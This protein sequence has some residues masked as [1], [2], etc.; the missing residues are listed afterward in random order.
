MK[1]VFG[2]KDYLDN[3]LVKE[4]NNVIHYDELKDNIFENAEI[5]YIFDSNKDFE[6]KLLKIKNKIKCPIVIIGKSYILFE[7]ARENNLSVLVY[8]L[9]EIFGKWYN[10]DRIISK[11][12]S[13][14]ETC[15]REDKNISCVMAEDLINELASIKPNEI[16]SEIRSFK[17]VYNVNLS[18]IY[19]LIISFE[20]VRENRIIPNLSHDF[21][22]KLWTVYLSYLENEDLS[23]ELITHKDNRGSFTE[24]LK[25]SS[26][27]QMSIN[28][29]KPGIMKG[30]HWHKYNNKKYLVLKGKGLFRLRKIY[31]DK[32]TEYVTTE[33]KFEIIDIPAGYVYTIENIGSEDMVIVM[34]SSELFDPNNP[35]SYDLEI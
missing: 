19:D 34:W 14:I 11:M 35:D 9:P 15:Q 30:N 13:S 16:N 5:I 25:N 7:Q 22:K 6:E 33:E 1:L 8:N 27:G 28:V 31:E 3:L 32:I 26:F 12:C 2:N 4:L 23:Y 21:T 18:E 29:F 20:K 10:R 24:L 17:K